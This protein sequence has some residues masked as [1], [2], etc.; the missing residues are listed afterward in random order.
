MHA[1]KFVK[2]VNLSHLKLNPVGDFLSVLV[3]Y[4]AKVVLR[5][6][7]LITLRGCV[8]NNQ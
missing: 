4:G 7:Y 5:N 8:M 3:L 2:D 6:Y 1:G